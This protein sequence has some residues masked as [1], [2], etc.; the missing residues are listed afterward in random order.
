VLILSLIIISVY[1]FDFVDKPIK[2]QRFSNSQCL[3]ESFIIGLSANMSAVPGT[4]RSC[5]SRD[6][7]L[8]YLCIV[9]DFPGVAWV[10]FRVN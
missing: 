1:S 4:S 6:E 3:A 2:D 5:F 10:T 7:C 9:N 8:K